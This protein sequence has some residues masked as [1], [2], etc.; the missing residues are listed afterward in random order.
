VH[1]CEFHGCC[2]CRLTAYRTG[3]YCVSRSDR[4]RIHWP[5]TATLCPVTPGQTSC[6]ARWRWWRSSYSWYGHSTFPR[7]S[8]PVLAVAISLPVSFPPVRRGRR[9]VG[10]AAAVHVSTVETYVCF[11]T[12]VFPTTLIP[13]R[14]K[15]LSRKYGFLPAISGKPIDHC[16]KLPESRG[17]SDSGQYPLRK[18]TCRKAGSCHPGTNCATS[19]NSL[20]SRWCTRSSPRPEGTD[21]KSSVRVDGIAAFQGLIGP[22]RVERTLDDGAIPEPVFVAIWRTPGTS[23]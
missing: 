11:L 17:I 16:R 21:Y 1:P 12:P 5:R 23:V 6:V 22:V 9:I 13:I 10:A 14:E 3:Q 4:G 7:L 20:S 18:A 19:G 8:T 2:E 15:G